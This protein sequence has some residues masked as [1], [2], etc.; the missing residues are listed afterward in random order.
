[1]ANLKSDAKMTGR[2]KIVLT[3]ANGVVKDE[4]DIPNLVVDAGKDVIAARIVGTA[5]DVMSHMAVGTDSTSPNAADTALGSEAGRVAIT[6]GTATDNVVT[7]TATFGAGTGTGALVEAGM[8][9]DASTGDMLCRTT[10]SVV[11]KAAGDSVA[12]TW[13]VTVS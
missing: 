12:I 1:M 3:D 13:T 7:Y 4:R 5:S 2:L 10:F 9:N 11:N 8:F 6:S